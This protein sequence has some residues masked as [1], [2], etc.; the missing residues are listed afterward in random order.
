MR[1]ELRPSCADDILALI[2]H[3]APYR[4]K[5]LTAFADDHAIGIGGLVFA[6][7]GTVWASVK[8]LDEGRRYKVALW[9]AAKLCLEDAAAHGI[10]TIYAKDEPGRAGARE[11]LQRLGFSQSDGLWVW[12]G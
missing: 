5:A 4:V 8:L 12:R 10:R 2:G 7:D 11:F 1:V 3:P 9:R 6:P